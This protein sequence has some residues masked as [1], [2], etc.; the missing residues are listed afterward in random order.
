MTSHQKTKTKSA[1]TPEGIRLRKQI[2][3]KSSMEW[4][5]YVPE[6]LHEFFEL[7]DRKINTEKYDDMF[8]TPINYEHFDRYFSG[9]RKNKAP[10]K[11]NIR[12]DHICGL[13]ERG[14]K[15]ICKLISIPYIME[16]GNY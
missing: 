11:S 8:S 16:L 6:Q 5:E 1:L 7:G 2:A 4:K 14:K 3:D 13:H 12:I 10:G 15:D 9:K